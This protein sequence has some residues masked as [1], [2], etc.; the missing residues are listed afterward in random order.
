MKTRN[1]H[2]EFL[3]KSYANPE[4]L[5]AYV[6]IRTKGLNKKEKA[7]SMSEV[8]KALSWLNEHNIPSAIS[9][10]E[11]GKI[12]TGIMF[13]FTQKRL[14]QVLELSEEKPVRILELSK[15]IAGV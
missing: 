11:E 6:V 13:N 9:K 14:K 10:I 12:N 3:C 1:E 4:A 15:V 7:D 8:F 5:G 2:L